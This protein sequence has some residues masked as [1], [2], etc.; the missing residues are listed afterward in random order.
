MDLTHFRRII[1]DQR[2][3]L[4]FTDNQQYTE[5][6][7]QEAIQLNSQL[8]QIISGIRRCG[9]STL[10]LMSLKDVHFA[11]V[12]FD[13][14]RIY[15]IDSQNLDTLLEALYSVYGK[16]EYL[17]LDEIQNIDSWY[18]F[19]NRLLRRK[20]KI[21]ITG[22]NS[23]LLSKEMASHLTGRYHVINL[24]P[25]SFTEYL[26]AK[27]LVLPNQETTSERGLAINLFTQYLQDGGF[28]EVVQGEDKRSYIPTLF[29]AII[30][31]DIIYRYNI[32]HVR[33]FREIATW[34]GANYSSEISFNRIKNIFGLGSENTAKNYLSY[35]EEAW[36]FIS[37]SK[38]SY[39][40]QESLRNQKIYLTDTSLALSGSKHS[41]NE[42]KLFENFVFL[43][44]FRNSQRDYTEIFYYKSSIEIDFVV[45][46]SGKVTELIQAAWNLSDK[47]TLNR[48]TRALLTASKELK[49]ENLTIITLNESFL[50]E[51][52][53]L[54]IN[55]L[56]V[57]EWL[58]RK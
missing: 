40:N 19:V 37:L 57:F 35:L 6:A 50:I 54:K 5:R 20:I 10:A 46:K 17:F 13:D 39:K 4:T 15:S 49:A 34:L 1:L 32:R 44:L 22:S 41:R 55:V 28:P 25:Y 18:L 52:D 56:T 36:L 47:K 21:I 45:V 43:Q 14:E 42:G 9:K 2:E 31:R 8:V 53:D 23:K 26:S 51:K 3:E 30:T 33:T 48:E 7:G 16:F 29:E 38:F 27:K 24:L 58:D 12:N 11:Y